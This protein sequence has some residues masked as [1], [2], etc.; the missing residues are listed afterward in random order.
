MSYYRQRLARVHALDFTDQAR[1]A[2]A[3]LVQLLDGGLVIDL[4]CGPGDLSEAVSAAGMDYLGIDASE[5][6]LDLA[7][8]RYPDR[9]FEHGSA[10]DVPESRAAAIVAVGEV[11]NYASDARAGLT[12]LAAW[13]RACHRS[14]A[15]GGV[16]LLDVAGPL[17]ADPEPRTVEVRGDGYWMQVTT[18]TDPGR[19][20]LTR[21]ITVEDDEGEYR[22][23]H[24]LL[25]IDPM[26][27]M[28]AAQAAGFQITA[29]ES[30]APDVP[31]ARGWSAFLARATSAQ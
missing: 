31:L 9:R 5:S 26:D 17:R 13:I 21:T 6:M 12:G 15:P 18:Q 24:E 23:V 28:A 7:R 4:G 27:V 1:A 29:L 22:E 20:I 30:Y 8:E 3:L 10:F 11:V 19:Q 2:S 25:L 16:L 14:L